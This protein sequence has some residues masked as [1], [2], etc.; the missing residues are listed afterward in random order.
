MNF[1]D[2]A[3]AGGFIV[4]DDDDN[5]ET[6]AGG[7][8]GAE[9]HY[10]S[11]M[12]RDFDYFTEDDLLELTWQGGGGGGGG[13]S[14]GRPALSPVS[15]RRLSP[16]PA[17]PEIVPGRMLLPEQPTLDDDHPAAPS[18]EEMAAWLYPIVSGEVA[19]R[20]TEA[21]DDVGRRAALPEMEDTS[22][23]LTTTKMWGAVAHEKDKKRPVDFIFL[24]KIIIIVS[25]RTLCTSLEQP[26]S[27]SLTMSPTQDA[28]SD[29]SKKHR[30]PAHNLTEKKRRF[31]ITEKLRTLQRLVPGCDKC[32][33]V[34]TLE[35][36]I[37]YMRSLQ[38]Q[39]KLT[40]VVA[41]PAALSPPHQ[42]VDL[43]EFMGHQ[44]GGGGGGGTSFEQPAAASSP[45][46]AAPPEIVPAEPGMLLPEQPPCDHP[47][48]PSEEEM[49][50]WL[51]PIVCG[52][53]AAGQLAA[54]DGGGRRGAL[55]EMEGR[56]GTTTKDAA[57]DVSGERKKHTSSAK[58]GARARSS[59]NAAG[60]H[61]LS[62]K[63]RRV[64]ISEKLKTLQRLVPGCDKSNQASTLEQ[65]I[66]YMR[67]LQHQ[68]KLIM[69][70]VAPPPALYPPQYLMPPAV[71][72]SLTTVP[73]PAGMVLA[74]A[75]GPGAPP[76]PVMVPC[77]LPYPA[78]LLPPPPPMYRPA[79]AAPGVPP[80]SR[81]HGY[82]S[83]NSSSSLR[84]KH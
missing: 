34:S 26:Y 41:P 4:T 43:F 78:V 63:R 8:G 51:Y 17:P 15:Y 64:K 74:A 52:G 3:P 83:K 35:Q 75:P 44:G 62:E 80:A 70:V 67:S 55:P 42:D 69:S 28:A 9:N 14:F 47:A 29:D 50:A 46:P 68:L 40:S 30:S 31:K 33:Q 56:P 79:E 24:R 53:E 25:V 45:E 18:E 23:A 65:T 61:N 72:S 7:G 57:S 73:M 11:N 84:Q 37:Q 27:D 82:R 5:G 20:R 77:M 76:P 36:T 58:A 16:E 49:A 22:G 48:A 1:Q 54:T 19:G 59:R 6:A 32:N 71:T 10:L 81:R 38:H 13:S 60:A 12:L 66:Q 39:L 2:P 21:D